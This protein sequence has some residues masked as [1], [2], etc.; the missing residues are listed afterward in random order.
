MGY[1]A[2][3]PILG[4]L[5]KYLLPE[6]IKGVIAAIP[7]IPIN[8]TVIEMHDF[9]N[10]RFWIGDVNQPLLKVG[11]ITFMHSSNKDLLYEPNPENKKYVIGLVNP[12][13]AN[14]WKGN[15]KS[16]ASL[17]AMIGNDTDIRVT[18]VPARNEHFTLDKFI[19]VSIY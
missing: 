18:Q 10:G 8:I 4:D 13:D 5:K 19:A 12:A 1:F 7:Q 11:R 9:F 15:E 2:Q 14:S 6:F 17:E 16:S 3:S